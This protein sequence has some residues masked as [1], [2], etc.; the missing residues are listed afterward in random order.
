MPIFDRSSASRLG[1]AEAGL[2]QSIPGLAKPGSPYLLRQ[3]RNHSWRQRRASLTR[4]LIVIA[5]L[6]LF[7][8]LTVLVS[9]KPQPPPTAVSTRRHTNVWITLPPLTNDQPTSLL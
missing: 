5:L 3:P 9:E 4:A 2:L 7:C 1:C 6:G 8:G